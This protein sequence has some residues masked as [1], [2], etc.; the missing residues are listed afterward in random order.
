MR[1]PGP[2]YQSAAAAT[3][4]NREERRQLEQAD[5]KTALANLTGMY[6]AYNFVPLSY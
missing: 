5:Y 6:E 1:E 4:A 2:Q 3:Q